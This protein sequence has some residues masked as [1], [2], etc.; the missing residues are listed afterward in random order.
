[1]EAGDMDMAAGFILGNLYSK[2]LDDRQWRRRKRYGG[3]L[4][5]RGLVLRFR[6]GKGWE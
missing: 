1:M 3:C 2:Y 4:L 6:G 5:S